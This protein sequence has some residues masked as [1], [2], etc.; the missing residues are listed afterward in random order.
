[1]KVRS[2]KTLLQSLMSERHLTRERAIEA[3]DGRARDMGVRD[4]ALSLRQLDRWLAGDLATLPRPSLCMVVEMEF[5]Y[6]VERL[7]A[8]SDLVEASTGPEARPRPLDQLVSKAATE[9][10]RADTLAGLW[11]TSYQFYSEEGIRY[12]ADITRVT[13]QSSR[14][15][16]AKN[17]PPDPRTQGHV[18]AFRN[19]IEAQL[20]N[21]HVIGHW[22]NI[23]DTR[24]F[25]SI[26]LAILPGEA[27]ME[28]YY[29]AFSSD[30]RVDVMGWK[31]V[32]LEPLSL[33]DVELPQVALKEPDAI[34]TLLEH[35]AYDA[36]LTLAAVAERG[37]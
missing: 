12:H 10:A 29:T 31:W 1:M 4:F 11:I 18:P 27:V 35:S 22:R 5:G 32:R 16:T 23:S 28:G 8:F 33:P 37:A 24:Y 3:L 17:Y 25:G 34:Y 6:P 36:P 15:L 13:P 21:R 26:H 30:I 19:E 20:A 2:P 9:S 7:L 14:R